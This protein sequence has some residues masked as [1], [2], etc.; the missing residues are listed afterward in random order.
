[1]KF[2]STLFKSKLFLT[3]LLIRLVLM[4]FTA[5]YD[6]R[7]IN[8]AIFQLPFNHVLNVYEIA[9]SGP[10]DYITRVNFG[11]EYFIY[12][13]LTY[14]TLGSFMWIL[15][16][17]YGHEFVNWIQGYGNDVLSVITHPQVFR[18]LFLMKIPYL[19]FDIL[20]IFG[21]Y[22]MVNNTKEQKI[23][24]KYWWLNPITIFLPYVWG[25][26]DIIP[27]AISVVA[28]WLMQKKPVL[29][30]MILGLAAAYKNYPLMFLPVVAVA[31]AK[32]WKQGISMFVAGMLPFILTT[33]PYA[34]HSFFRE[35]VLVSWQ[36]QKML[37]FMMGI[38]GDIGIYPFVIA[39]TLIGF[40]SFYFARKRGDAIGPIVMSLLLYYA[41]TNFHQQW[42]LWI[43]PF[44]VFYAVKY[45][46][47]RP[48][49]YWIIGLFFLRLVSLQGNVTTE[50]FLWIAPAIDDLP[51]SRYL[52]GLLY[53]I[54]KVRNIIASFYFATAIWVSGWIAT[55][56]ET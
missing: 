32:N 16:P 21:L 44:L 30:S 41:T 2:I 56:E 48:L 54:N 55:K 12:P 49:F 8:F 13:P 51:K 29:G 3:G 15:K 38:G 34:W 23:V 10:V 28:V 42:F 52:V 5:H 18:Y 1:M 39:Y 9:Q 33:A 31:I 35:T 19:F 25:Q 50:L 6:L 27:A 36:S 43:L 47:F 7:G 14:F 53:D 40:W 37:D 17:L 24:L 11:R 26:F 4:P 45:V 20:T 46:S 22:K